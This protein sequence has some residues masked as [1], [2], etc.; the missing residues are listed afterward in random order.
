ME[1]NSNSSF[2]ELFYSLCELLGESRG[3]LNSHLGISNE[4]SE[5]ENRAYIYYPDTHAYI[6]VKNNRVFRLLIPVANVKGTN[7]DGPKDFYTLDGVELN[8]T[9]DE[10]IRQWGDPIS[11][12]NYGL[13]YDYKVSKSG[14]FFKIGFGFEE[15]NEYVQRLKYFTAYPYVMHSFEDNFLQSCQLLGIDSNSLNQE[16]GEPDNKEV[17]KDG[18]KFLYY[19]KNDVLFTLQKDYSV[20]EFVAS[21]IN[22]SNQKK[23][24]GFYNFK[25][26]NIGIT[27]E[28]I[29]SKWG[30][31]TGEEDY[32]WSYNNLTGTTKNGYHFEI[33]L[34][35]D[36]NNP[37]I[38]KGFGGMLYDYGSSS[39]SN[40][41]SKGGCFIATACYGNYNATE[42]LVLRNYRDN[43]LLKT[44]IGRVAVEIYYLISPPIARLL[45]KSNS[46]KAFVRKNILA[47][48]V[49][50]IKRNQ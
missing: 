41:K 45:D 23:G 9:M 37:N 48:I 10:I 2:K 40:E 27:R 33:R 47:P 50:K 35:F 17:D 3:E 11:R 20:T 42:V 46:L 26:L 43:V 22:P 5:D 4:I 32:V 18:K 39:K 24:Q 16:I 28:D 25:G 21:P 36:T 15:D 31:P 30:N 44:S 29:L 34:L 7:Y 13:E 8:M 6:G 38:L 12:N 49:S 1:S 14:K 19:E